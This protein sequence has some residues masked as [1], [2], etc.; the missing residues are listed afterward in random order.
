MNTVP[1]LNTQH[2]FFKNLFPNNYYWMEQPR[3][4]INLKKISFNS[5]DHFKI[6]PATVIIK[7]ES[8]LLQD[9]DLIWAIS[10]NINSNIT[11]KV[12]SNLYATMIMTLNLQLISSSIVLFSWKLP[13]LLSTISGTDARLLDNTDFVL[14]Q[15]L[16]FDNKSNISTIILRSLSQQ[17]IVI[18]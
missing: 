16:D 4:W 12:Q 7:K 2:V 13:T 17:L 14:T 15:T 5:C 9:L 6:L 1:L 11:F 3:S 18:S 8:N 10:E